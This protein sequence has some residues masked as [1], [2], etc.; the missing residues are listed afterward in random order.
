LNLVAFLSTSF[1]DIVLPFICYWV[2]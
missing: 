2:C 1:G